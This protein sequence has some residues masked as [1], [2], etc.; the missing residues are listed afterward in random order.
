VAAPRAVITGGNSGIGRA[1]AVVL[2]ERGWDVGITFRNDE[3]EAGEVADEVRGLG[4]NVEVRRAELS[5]PRAGAEAVGALADAL[6]GIDALVNNAGTGTTTPFLELDF[7]EWRRVLAVD[8]DAA[9][10]CAQEAARRMVVAGD[11]GRIVNVTSVHEHVP[12]R[13]A[14][15]YCAAK[16]GLGLLTKVMALELAEHGI[17]VNSIAPGQI[18]TPL[19]GA[20]DK[21][22]NTIERPAIPLRRPGHAREIGHAIA[23]LCSEEA[24]YTTGASLVVDGGLVLMAAVYNQ[25]T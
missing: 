3:R 13:G 15:P 20:H 6:G 16:A 25:D 1:T 10:V 19:T 23:Y 9:F 2:A 17:L 21:D 24:S 7:T 11:G 22:P 8:L 12:L 4:R 18:A 5:E 14:A